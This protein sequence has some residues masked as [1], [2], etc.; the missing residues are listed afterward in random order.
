MQAVA[1][2][3]GNFQVTLHKRPRFID[4]DACTGCGDCAK[5][6]P[7][8]L[9]NEFDERLGPRKATYKLYPQAIPGA[10]A[11]EKL[12]TAPCRVACP[13]HL[14]VQGYVAM[15]KEGKYEE[16]VK[17]ILQDL[18]L[19]GV[20]GRVCPH[21]CEK[22]CRRLEVDSAISIREL[23]RVAADH[24]NLQDLPLPEITPRKE[25]V[26]I[27]GSGP[28][29]LTAAY[30]LALDGY[31]VT[32]Y[33]SMP[34]PGGML[35][36]GIP[37]HRLPR[38]VLD[39][40][41]RFI[42][43]FGVNIQTGVRIG[44]D[45]TLEDLK[46]HGA[47]AIFL[48]MG[49]W[50]SYKLGLPGEDLYQGVDD[51]LS[52]LR[53]VHLGELKSLSG[54]A[55]IIG[56]GHS[57]IDAARVAL[58]LGAEE[59][60]IIYRRSRTEMLAEQEE[61]EEAEKEGVKILFQVAPL[62]IT[63]EK[64]RVTG[65]ECIRTRLMEADT[66]GRRKPIPIEGSEFFVEARHIIPAI[67]QEPDL[68]PL[69]SQSGLEVSK[70]NLLVVNPETL[71]TSQPHI[72]AG[73]DV[74]TGP[75]TVIEAVEAGKRAAY[76]MARYMQGEELPT[77]WIEEPAA[78]T[79]WKPI[80]AEEPVKSRLQPPTL[81]LEERLTGFKEVNQ[82]S[83][84]EAAREEAERC[85][86][87]GVCCECLQC[88]AACKAEA[89]H[90]HQQAEDL[91]VKV[92][93]IIA[94]PGFDEFDP[95][96]F[97][98]YP[99]GHF[100]NVVTSIEFERILSASGPFQ[101][102]MVRPS[103]HKEPERIAWLQC[104]GS[105]DINHCDNA[106]CSA[107]CCMYA[108][109]EAMIAREHSKDPLDTAIFFMD[110]RTY[111]KDFE[112][113]Y[114]Q[115][116]EK[117]VR[118]IRSRI[119][120]IDKVPETEDL[121][122]SYVNEDGRIESELFDMVVLSVGLEPAASSRELA[123]K[124]GI[125]LDSHR[126]A[127][128]TSFAPVSTT[129]E[130]IYACGAFQ[131]PKDIPYSVMEASA[132]ACAASSKLALARGTLIKEKTFPQEQDVS[133]QTPRI[134]VFVCNCGINIGGVVRVPEVAEYAKTLPNVVY[135]QEN[136]FSCSQ[137]AQDRLRD[138]I[139]QEKLNRVVVAA[140][141]PRTHEPLF[142]ET[143]RAASLNKYLFE[144]A[145][146]R[147]QDS[148]VHQN[149]PDAATEKAKDLVRM[150]VAKASLLEPLK[151]E[152]L[153]ITQSGLVVGGGIAGMNAALGL[154]DQGY[155]VHLIEKGGELGGEARHIRWSW[156]GEDVQTYLQNLIDKVN[157]HGKV[158][159]HLNSQLDEVKGFV[160][161][162]ESRISSN[163]SEQ[164]ISHGVAIL[165][166]GAKAVEP[167][168]YLYGKH[169]RV[170]RWHDVD[171]LIA[172]QDPLVLQGKTAVFIQCVGSREPQRP[173]C[174]KICCTHSVS[175]AIKLKEVNPKMD[176][177][178]LYRDIRT[179][180]AREDLYQEA[181]AKGVI[182]VRFSLEDKPRVEAGGDGDLLVTVKDHILGR[183][184]T[185]NPDFINLATA[186][187]PSGLE[188]LANLFKVPLN[189]DKFFLEAHAKLRPVDFA[190]DGVFLCGLAHYPK[191]I[192]ESVAQALAAAS[193]AAT[194][195]S[196]KYIETSGLVAV[197]D[198]ERCVGCQGCLDVCPFGAINY[199]EDRHI[200]QVNK[201]L[202]KGCGGCAAT[203]PSGSVQLMGF[204]PQQLYAQ[205]DKALA[206]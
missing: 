121:E 142:Q 11:I 122:I 204:R 102:H 152:R 141:S 146:I 182:F 83:G 198:A 82:L 157:N 155:P 12:D 92:G 64:G 16:A 38:S 153:G 22:S 51:V 84:E 119:H 158:T 4:L 164:A 179:Y 43:R 154:A 196:Q 162:F 184:I 15:V 133:L 173:Y 111:G 10:Y 107:V 176:V 99:Y 191:P 36:Y 67:G 125:D 72:F 186:I 87:C 45:L 20:L 58:R 74:I 100:P 41:I 52:F 17:I 75:A 85:L 78:G 55:V 101:G 13:A 116:K 118:F 24:V 76:Y 129:V 123:D 183:Y 132:A 93:S 47:Q 206:E 48:A 70:W 131:G 138:I 9:P 151:E 156:K 137:D 80:P 165:A 145:N 187:A 110:M 160:G 167:D 178:I 200:C 149:D 96:R 202:C 106:Y 91:V 188:E 95:S 124:L 104:V 63:G 44:R 57:A 105:R 61:V 27:V 108:I 71:Q 117:G 197:I 79:N 39:A 205:I 21:K 97:D 195:L 163:G 201:A 174:S 136:L 175:S 65:I 7:V 88:V 5:V 103:D 180:G 193:R 50:K 148:W 203:C 2:Q 172:G 59:A 14:N 31:Q 90:H 29:G 169:P 54:K 194:V 190:T 130:G 94:A 25:K 40:E 60:C 166:I 35:R 127:A 113:Y 139:A 128:T 66:T 161:N 28:G 98:A 30:F 46:D 150:A 68:G 69:E 77:E 177:Y 26:A 3:E 189:T 143:M 140:C 49:A 147:D 168:E 81:E 115:A 109:K 37:E 86:N 112:R 192:E 159:V 42:Q 23:K 34:E 8:A 18:P 56:G 1:G 62:R 19:P 120:T 134:G 181:R 199:F 135:T 144:M 53:D 33:E 126:F 114:N 73:G 6:C 89:V 170:F 185:L 171:D 32:I